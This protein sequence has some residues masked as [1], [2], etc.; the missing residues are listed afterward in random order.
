MILSCPVKH[1]NI[2][3]DIC[4]Y[5]DYRKNPTEGKNKY[6]NLRESETIIEIDK[7]INPIKIK[8]IISVN[9]I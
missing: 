7:T 6:Y 2:E 3:V 5:V 8:K 9:S 1:L 4:Q